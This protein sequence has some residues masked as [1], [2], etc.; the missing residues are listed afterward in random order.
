MARRT[1]FPGRM[2]FPRR[3]EFLLASPRR[4]SR[5]QAGLS[6]VELMIAMALL[7][8]VAIGILPMMMRALADNNRGWEATEA[9]NFAQ[10]ELEPMLATPYE[11][12]VLAVNPGNTER[13]TGS[14]WAEGDADLTGDVDEGWTA[15]PTG[16]GR[17]FWT[18]STFVRWYDVDDPLTPL[19][20]DTD[21]S[22]VTLKEV[23]VQLESAREGG[24]LGAG[25]NVW[26]RVLRS[27]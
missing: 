2:V 26:I 11:N 3:I 7:A 15:D 6:L 25:Q 20:G 13:V 4:R 24:S 10:S 21:P 8:F 17:V 18:R 27:F 14:S 9:S 1:L 12:P 23:Q 16:K 5:S 22:E 19:P